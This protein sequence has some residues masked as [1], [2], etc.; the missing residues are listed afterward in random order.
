MTTKKSAAK[1]LSKKVVDL[2]VDPWTDSEWTVVYGE[3]KSGPGRPHVVKPIFKV[4]GEK[5]PKASLARV[6]AMV[7]EQSH[8]TKGVYFLHDSLGCARYAGR[9]KV[10]DRIEYRFDQ[11]P[12]GLVYFSFYIIQDK[13]H[14]REIETALIRVASHSLV[15]NDRKIR[16][17]IEPGDV[18]DYEPGTCF[19]QRQRKKG[20]K[21]NQE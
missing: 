15:F 10:F 2:D 7:D 19:V 14:E 16:A 12:L 5:L 6:K 21:L 4:V 17:S 20:P 13:K 11:H 18:R 3:L 8:D 1:K 9:G